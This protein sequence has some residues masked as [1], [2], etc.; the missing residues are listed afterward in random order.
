MKRSYYGD[1]GSVSTATMRPQDL[2]PTFADYA[3]SLR[4]SKAE[5]K[6]VTKIKHTASKIANG[7]FG[8]ND[9]YWQDVVA[10]WDLEALFDILNNHSPAYAYFGS[11]PGN[12]ADYGFWLV[13]DWEESFD[14]IKVNDTGEVPKGYTGEVLHVNDHGNVTLYVASRG[15]LREVWALV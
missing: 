3:D 10:D 9:A 7:R 2:I 4:L 11:H 1:F 12:G 8:D 15:R 13:E 6:Q 5:R 14:G